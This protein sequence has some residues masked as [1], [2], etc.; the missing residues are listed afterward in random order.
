M[1][2]HPGMATID[3][4]RVALYYLPVEVRNHLRRE[5]VLLSVLGLAEEVFFLEYAIPGFRSFAS[6]ELSRASC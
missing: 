1:N 3:E 4:V 6:R 2:W 5:G